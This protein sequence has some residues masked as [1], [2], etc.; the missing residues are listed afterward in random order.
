[1]AFVLKGRDAGLDLPIHQYCNDWFSLE[2]GTIVSPL[3][4]QLTPEECVEVLAARD[5]GQ[6]GTMFE[7][8]ELQENGTFTRIATMAEV[9][10]RLIARLRERG[11]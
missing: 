4:L 8:F 11:Q 2:D 6:T 1:M 5:E 10:A 9:R 7:E 3:K